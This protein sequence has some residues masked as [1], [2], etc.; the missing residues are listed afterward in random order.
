MLQISFLYIFILSIIAG[1]IEGFAHAHCYYS[2][3]FC[4]ENIED[5]NATECK[6]CQK[7]VSN[8]LSNFGVE[9]VVE[10]SEEIFSFIGN[11]RAFRFDIPDLS[12]D[13]KLEEYLNG[14]YE[15]KTCSLSYYNVRQENKMKKANY[16]SRNSPMLYSLEICD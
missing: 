14:K 10:I 5:Q 11:R 16:L 13:E 9:V 8:K 12:D 3:L 7:D 6:S 1:I 4:N 2:C 15:G